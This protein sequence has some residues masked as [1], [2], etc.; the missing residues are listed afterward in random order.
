[1]FQHPLIR[2]EFTR[3]RERQLRT[4]SDGRR[5]AGTRSKAAAPVAHEL[6]D[7]VHRARIGDEQA[8]EALV[9][10]F[11]PA[12][13][14]TARSYRLNVSD[15]E[16]AVQ[17]TW[18]AAVRHIERIRE[19]EA[20]GGWLMVTVRREAIRMLGAR[21]REIPVAELPDLTPAET[22]APASRLLETERRQALHNAVGSL[23][24][25]QRALLEVLFTHPDLTY[26]EL[27]KRLGLP[28][29]SIGP[30]RQRA[31]ARLRRNRELTALVS[32]DPAS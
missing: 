28:V 16:D 1:M 32:P 21:Q 11:T 13:R 14:A 23:P 15:V 7:L 20:I 22:P 9:A 30:T 8:W 4:G 29:G 24:G 17:T 19:P 12:L 27:S 2:E 6:A 10:K 26:D 25:H 5:L 3:Q 18:A 31:L